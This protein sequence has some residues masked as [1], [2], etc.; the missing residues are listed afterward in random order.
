MLAVVFALSAVVVA[1]ASAK[2]TKSQKVHIRHKLRKQIKKNPRMIKN[3]RW[4]KR[5]SLVD[6][7][8][9]V[10]I[11]LRQPCTGTNQVAANPPTQ[12]TTDCTGTGSGLN[13]RSDN[14]ANIDLGPSLGQRTIQLGGALKAKIQFSDSFDGGALGN[15]KLTLLPGKGLVT[16]SVP[17]LWNEDVSSTSGARSDV[18]FARAGQTAGSVTFN[19]ASATAVAGATQGCTDWTS[20]SA[21]QTNAVSSTGAGAP[22]AGYKA[23]WYGNFDDF[24]L[25]TGAGD[26][27]TPF[28]TAGGGGLPGY[29]FADLSGYPT[30]VNGYLPIYPGMDNP[31]NLV[32]DKVVGNNDHLGPVTDPFPQAP[33]LAAANAGDTVLRTNALNLDIAQAGIAVNQA[34]GSSDGGTTGGPTGGQNIVIGAS[35]GQANLFGDIP[36]KPAGEG[37]DVTV[38]LATK[39]SSIIR[40]TD[41][42]VFSTPL[43]SG[44]HYPAGIFNC[45]Q[46][47]TGQVQNYLPGIHLTGGLHIS[48]AITKEGDLR[49]AKATISTPN[50]DNASADVTRVALSACL[51]PF[52][53]YARYPGAAGEA[54]Q[55]AGDATQPTI[56]LLNATTLG[57]TMLNGSTSVNALA[58]DNA[59]LPLINQER[60]TPPAVDCGTTP[61]GIVLKSGLQS[62]TPPGNVS[63][64]NDGKKVTVAGDL[65]VNPV[66]V[67][68]IIGDVN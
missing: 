48:P 38:S 18:N 8:L 63:V 35:G 56:P 22:V 46:I 39:I 41:Q 45:R 58:F 19:G 61:A 10:T 34:D 40:I 43:L 64:P 66:A 50:Y 17:L 53:S 11:K 26:V 4:L 27:T 67:D 49:I 25:H 42:D 6:F 60:S 57:G 30:V 51:A 54:S 47:W 1:P 21:G 31:N 65:K 7:S 37:I 29:P 14:T 36:G 68:V 13:D 33:G 3:K 55:T 9:P 12:I 28:G 2:L 20:A 23:L 5:A 24:T 59:A 52:A 32:T 44:Q 15:V 62:L 16:S